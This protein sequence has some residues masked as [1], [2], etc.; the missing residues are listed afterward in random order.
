MTGLRWEWIAVMAIV[1]PIGGVLAALPVWRTGQMILGNLAGSIV[2]LGSALALIVR[3]SIEIRLA[4]AACLD[5]GFTCFPTPSAFA[6]YAIY[7]SL[8]MTSN[9]W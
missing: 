5:A 4:T 2:I 3:E 9:T 8:G 1:P 6:R 7:A